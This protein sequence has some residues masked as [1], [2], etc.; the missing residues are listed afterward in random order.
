MSDS[1]L[2]IALHPMEGKQA[3]SPGVGY[4]S[5]DCSSCGRNLRYILELQQG[6]PFE[7]PLCSVKS[8]LLSSN[9]VQLRN[10]N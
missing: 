3:S 9:D 10:L 7:T 6:G 1:E 8:R 2:W 4:V 5:W